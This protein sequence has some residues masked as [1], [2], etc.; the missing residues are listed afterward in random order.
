MTEATATAIVNLLTGLG[1][2][3][4][5]LGI[6]YLLYSFGSYISR[7]GAPPAAPPAAGA[8]GSSPPRTP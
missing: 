8:G 6:A 7:T 1:L 2:F 4:V 5:L 3:L